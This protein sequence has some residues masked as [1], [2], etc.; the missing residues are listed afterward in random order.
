MTPY[1]WLRVSQ[2]LALALAL[3]VSCATLTG[4]TRAKARTVP[5]SP[6][7]DMPVPPPRDVE[8]T[9]SEPP[10]PMTLPQEPARNAPARPR[11]PAPAT[12]DQPRA[13]EAPK[14]EPP[15]PETP[16]IAPETPKPTEEPPKPPPTLQTIPPQN[17]VEVE[18]TIRAT[19]QKATNDLNRID[20][21]ALNA[22]ART[23][24]DTAKKFVQ[25]AGDAL[26]RKNLEF[27][28]TLADKA[29]ALAA[30]LR[31]R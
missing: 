13:N 5:D 6:P 2:A 31:G 20:Y 8:V 1:S 26:G 23:Q 3:T 17:D 7:L 4:C 9:E 21:R 15:K 10:Q 16:V 27:A 24:Y 30:Q 25:Q 29:A 28:Q 12:R 22:D 18:R 19:M 14:T 11:P